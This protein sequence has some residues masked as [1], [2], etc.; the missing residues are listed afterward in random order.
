MGV[1]EPAWT[2]DVHAL[3]LVDASGSEASGAESTTSRPVREP[4]LAT[5][6][7]QR[8]SESVRRINDS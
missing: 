6:V 3:V 2:A 1:G 4:Q 5:A 7:T 8:R